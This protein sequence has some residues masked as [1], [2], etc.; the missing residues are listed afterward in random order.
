MDKY[1]DIFTT[2]TTLFQN[3]HGSVPSQGTVAWEQI[4]IVDNGDGTVKLP[5]DPMAPKF[6]DTM[7]L[8]SSVTFPNDTAYLPFIEFFAANGVYLTTTII[9]DNP[10]L[11][12][13]FPVFLDDDD[14]LDDECGN[15]VLDVCKLRTDFMTALRDYYEPLG[16]TL[17]SEEEVIG[18]S[19]DNDSDSFGNYDFAETLSR[20]EQHEDA[21]PAAEGGANNT[22]HG[23]LWKMVFGF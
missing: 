4:G 18:I 17:E 12:F 3:P 15:V 2:L 11:K 20:P 23:L 8:I 5:E 10:R 19:Y 13:P 22:E 14:E 16:I 9:H 1:P 7:S 21:P 6:I